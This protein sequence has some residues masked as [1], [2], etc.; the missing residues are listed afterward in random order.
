ML[1]MDPVDYCR[2]ETV[3]GEQGIST[4]CNHD[5]LK[6]HGKGHNYWMSF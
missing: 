4:P 3:I 5:L 6:Q 1:F 2:S